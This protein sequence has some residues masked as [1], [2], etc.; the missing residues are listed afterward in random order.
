MEAKVITN[1]ETMAFLHAHGLDV[2]PKGLDVAL[3]NAIRAL[4]SQYHAKPGQEGVAATQLSVARLGGLDPESAAG[5]HSDPLL[6]GVIT[7]ARI[8]KTGLTTLEAAKRLGVSDARIRQ[9]LHA[10]SLFALRDGWIWRLPSF[11]FT[12]G[13]ELPGWGEVAVRLPQDLSPIAL[14]QWLLLPNTDLIV[15]ENETPTSP[16]T[17]LLEGRP[18][19]VVAIL[20]GELA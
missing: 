18:P 2:D 5:K 3:R 1:V 20:A 17:W 19:A 10:R 16:R 4:R 11:Q 15:G 7:Y 12:E 13:G 9:R 14:E 8:L 6:I